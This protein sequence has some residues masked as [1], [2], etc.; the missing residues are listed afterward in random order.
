V[1]RLL[2]LD[3][4][5][6]GAGSA[7][8]IL[9]LGAE[10]VG[11]LGAGHQTDDAE[12]RLAG[13]DVAPVIARPFAFVAGPAG[14]AMESHGHT[15]E[16]AGQLVGH[17]AGGVRAV[18]ES[19]S[20][21]HLAEQPGMVYGAIAAIEALS[22]GRVRRPEGNRRTGMPERD[23]PFCARILGP[24]EDLRCL[25]GGLVGPD[26]LGRSCDRCGVLCGERRLHAGVLLDIERG[27]RQLE[28]ARRR[29][30][31]TASA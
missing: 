22:S 2:V 30:G 25:C 29:D 26:H 12:V 13:A 9:L 27:K 14:Y 21:L 6:D 16:R 23:G 10:L 1:D 15:A 17:D 31:A 8:K 19:L 3:R 28:L 11:M 4:D 5:P 7:M 24:T 20:A 18:A